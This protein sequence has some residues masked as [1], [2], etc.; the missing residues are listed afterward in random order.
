MTSD[1][2]RPSSRD[3]I[4]LRSGSGA[5]SV[6]G[7]TSPFHSHRS[8]LNIAAAPSAQSPQ[9]N[10]PP[11]NGGNGLAGFPSRHIRIRP[12]AGP[13][14]PPPPAGSWRCR[15]GRLAEKSRFGSVRRAAR[16]LVAWRSRWFLPKG[17]RNVNAVMQR[18][19][20]SLLAAFGDALV[21]FYISGGGFGRSAA[22]AENRRAVFVA[23]RRS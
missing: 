4:S 9:L 11:R 6:L 1:E 19:G 20:E 10:N 18:N 23:F 14:P 17:T 15:I 5:A 12:P 3:V 8:E 7:V 22:Q 21:N 2:K 16:W 13:L